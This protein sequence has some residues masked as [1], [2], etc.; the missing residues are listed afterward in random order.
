M[1]DRIKRRRQTS[2]DHQ[3]RPSRR[4]RVAERDDS[5]RDDLSFDG[6]LSDQ[7]LERQEATQNGSSQQG[8][9]HAPVGE[10]GTDDEGGIE[11]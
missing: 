2:P 1:D 10:S 4:D 5:P 7:E 11:R 6:N 9:D 8:E 3:R